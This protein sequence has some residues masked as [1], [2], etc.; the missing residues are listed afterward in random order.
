VHILVTDAIGTVGR[1]V[2]RQLIAAGHTV[3][4]I[5]ERPN[6]CLDPSVELVCAS[7][8]DPVLQKL[9]D[10]ADAVIH[11]A[12]VDPTAPGSGDID[13]VAR[14]TH[15]A[16]RAGARLMLVSQAAG[17][18]S[19]YQPAEELVSTSWGPSLVIRIA[20][21][22]GRQLD[23]MVCRTVAT[24]LRTK[25]SAQPV[26][27]LHLD[28][29]VRFL[30]MAVQTDRTG[31]LDLASPDTVN[32]IT[33]WR[34]LR[35]VDPRFRPHQVRSWAQLIPEMDIA[36]VQEDWDFEFGWHPTDAVADT[37]RGLVGRR[38]GAAGATD[39]GSELALP[40]E[41]LPRSVPPEGLRSA[42]PDGLEG[43]FDDRI[44]ARFPV[45]S[46]ANLGEALPGPLTPITLDVQ[47]SGLRAASRVLGRALALGDVIGDEWGSRAVAVF[48]HR[49]YVGVSAN[50]V[51]AAQ[52]PGWD[53][54][55][56]AQRALADE[57][58]VGQLVPFGRPQLASGARG[59]VA[60]A[61]SAARSLGALR[62]LRADT[63]AYAAAA[64]A[65]H[66]AAERLTSLSDA[67]LGVRIPLLRDRIHQG[68]IL[69]ALWLIDAGVTAAVFQQT[70]AGFS[71]AGFGAIVES[72]RVGAETDALAALLRSDPPVCALAGEGNLASVRALSPDTA[73]SLD[74]AIARIGHRGPGE[75]ELASRMFSDDPAILLT[76]A[77]RAAAAPAD[78]EAPATLSRRLAA[79]ARGSRELVHDT[80]I[81]FTHELRMT[82]RELGSRWATMDLIDAADH[83]YFLTCDELVTQPADV[84]LR[85]KRR[86][87]ERERLQAQRPPDVI[88]TSWIPVNGNHDCPELPP[89]AD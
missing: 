7:L 58:Q 53:Q 45:F 8:S 67:S 62:H 42:A 33:A 54:Q 75:A 66:L 49:P 72:G 40:V 88:D 73:G 1:M 61:V 38:L 20:P 64:Q 41:V 59:S 47:L 79:N 19:L 5:A 86:R 43:E 87:A 26:R 18:P 63:R 37:A 6:A 48:G 51:A 9:A 32:L 74:A 2:A 3:S 36:A 13:G 70:K 22:V 60:K 4:G 52:L 17:L 24:L 30:V 50:L 12:P 16:A 27:V 81:W 25:V 84:R 34:L 65:E 31:A 69:T 85:I 28:D 77:A 46:A 71:V 55:A 44:D 21:P 23:W 10:E 29:L 57:T 68:W 82:L 14:V 11:L 56:V 15:A 89:E 78:P 83:V 80:T 39:H 76:A 35:S